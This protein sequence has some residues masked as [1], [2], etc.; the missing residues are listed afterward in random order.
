M[1]RAIP[2]WTGKTPDTAIP[3]RVQTRVFDRDGGQCRQCT[4]KVG[5][6]AEPFAFDHIIA[7]INGGQ[8]SESNLQL[9]CQH[10]HKAK[11]GEDVAEKS[12]VA[13]IRA[14]AIG[15]HQPKR[16]LHSRNTFK[17][18]APNVRDVNEDVT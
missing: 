16:K 11:T 18:S 9:L 6:G 5:P 7:L 3:P 10:C 13:R 1:A 14:K 2:P 4:R 15:V 8:H 12:R 17:P